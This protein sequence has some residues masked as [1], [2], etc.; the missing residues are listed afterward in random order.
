MWKLPTLW[1]SGMRADLVDGAV[2]TGLDLLRVLDDLVDEVAEVQ[3]EPELVLG[4]GALVLEDHPAI[5]VELAFIDVL[6]ADEGEVDGARIVGGRRGH[7]SP[8]AAA[9]SVRIGEPVPVDARRA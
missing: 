2:V 3:D 8:D 4:R 5:G 9:V 6:A 1:P 7:R